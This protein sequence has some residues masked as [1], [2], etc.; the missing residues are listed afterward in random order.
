MGFIVAQ[1]WMII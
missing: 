1:Q